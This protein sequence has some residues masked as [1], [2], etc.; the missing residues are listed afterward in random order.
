MSKKWGYDQKKEIKISHVHNYEKDLI[1]E[2]QLIWWM[3]ESDYSSSGTKSS[4]KE[5]DIPI[6][7]IFALFLSTSSEILLK[8]N[9]LL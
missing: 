5:T 6:M 4:V 9:G 1:S 7:I 8:N 3:K 2:M